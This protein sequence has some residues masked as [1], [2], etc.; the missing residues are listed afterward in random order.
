MEN[1]TIQIFLDDATLPIATYAPPVHFTLDTRQL[2]DGEHKMK[3]VATSSAGKEGIK[4]IHFQVR[5]GPDIVIHGLKEN[6]VVDDQIPLTINAYGSDDL[7]KFLVEGSESPIGIPSW[8]WI[9]LIAFIGFG[10]FYLIYAWSVS[11]YTS[12]F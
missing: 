7:S 11:N 2:T 4:V 5:N 9:L 12:F 10:A 8:I 3:I 6:Q 1:K